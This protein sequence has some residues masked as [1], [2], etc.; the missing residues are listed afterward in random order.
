MDIKQKSEG[1]FALYSDQEGKDIWKVGGPKTAT[2]ANPQYR[3]PYSFK[4]PVT[5]NAPTTGAAV[6]IQNTTGDDLLVGLIKVA[7]TTAQTLTINLSI[8]TGASSTTFCN[9]LIDAA[10]VHV[11]TTKS[12]FDN[13][14]DKGTS[15]LSTGL[16]SAGSFITGTFTG[17]HTA[18]TWV[19]NLY[20]TV[21]KA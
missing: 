13:I 5:T 20:V 21:E 17:G 2:Q 16:W 3:A 1:T 18:N 12:V 8:G 14:T 10:M 15:G 6:S 9:N 11:T 7:V 19:G 4:V